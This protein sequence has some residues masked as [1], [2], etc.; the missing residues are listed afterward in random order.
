MTSA[1]TKT[2]Q[3]CSSGEL[4]QA[5]EVNDPVQ[6]VVAAEIVKIKAEI[7]RRIN[8]GIPHCLRLWYA[9]EQ[10]RLTAIRSYNAAIEAGKDTPWPGPDTDAEY[11]AMNTASNNAYKLIKG[12]IEALATWEDQARG[13][14]FIRL[15]GADGAKGLENDISCNDLERGMLEEL[16]ELRMTLKN[17]PVVPM[18]QCVLDWLDAEQN[19]AKKAA[20]Y[21]AVALIAA[22]EWLPRSVEAEEV[23]KNQA[24]AYAKALLSNMWKKLT[25]V[26]YS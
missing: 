4:L 16:A 21:N 20:A 12:A 17:M 26:I 15:L 9:A 10:N 19:R 25:D 14:I 2:E 24:D 5:A 1:S 11:Q 6:K 13:Q 22:R 3:Q 7:D 23:E 18:P 8:Q